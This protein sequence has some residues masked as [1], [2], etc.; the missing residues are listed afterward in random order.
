MKA[1]LVS[2]TPIFLFATVA[3]A[4]TNFEK[5]F[6]GKPL[7]R[8][9]LVPDGYTTS[10]EATGDLNNDGADDIALI[11]RDRSN[12]KEG[13][14]YRPQYVLIFKGSKSNK[15]EI[16]KI[17]RSHFVNTH[18]N[19]MEPN[20]IGGFEIKNGVLTIGTSIALSAGSWSAGGCVMMWR[21]EK[22]GFRLIGLTLV[23][24]SR[25]CACGTTVDTNLLTGSK[26]VKTDR[27]PDGEKLAAENVERK[28]EK[29]K[30]VLWEQ[31]ELDKFCY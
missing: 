27:S 24:L 9:Q 6:N 1:F 16:W 18:P 20:G 15:Y 31:F 14:E 12:L 22:K 10:A 2:L 25:T 21:N 11:V 19:F 23:D 8:A 17:G 4:E 30:T 28:K 26:I 5:Q 29:P 3:I 7:T 13:D